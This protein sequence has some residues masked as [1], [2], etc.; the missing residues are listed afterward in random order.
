[1]RPNKTYNDSDKEKMG[2]CTIIYHTKE[3]LL[4]PIFIIFARK[5]INFI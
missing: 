1:M 2:G 4:I 3:G 5:V